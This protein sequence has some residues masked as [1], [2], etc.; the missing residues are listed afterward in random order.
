MMN[1]D[2]RRL[3]ADAEGA[4]R[5]GD[6]VGA[7]AAYLEASACAARYQLWRSALRYARNA[8][9]V[10]LTARAPIAR[11]LA[12]PRRVSPPADW[13]AYAQA[14][15]RRR[16]PAFGCRGA[17]AIIADDGARAACPGV[18]LVLELMMPADDL[19]ELRPVPAFAG[20]PRAMALLI[21]R[22]ALWHAPRDDAATPSAL[23]VV[24]DGGPAVRLDERGDWAPA[25]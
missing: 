8:L 21:A 20:M 2:L 10:E 15:D 18:G 7:Q 19:V 25:A 6:A 13:E 17:H 23:R 11:I 12:L 9:E 22:R 3:V 16:W 5:D 14:L 24:Y 1:V 4:V